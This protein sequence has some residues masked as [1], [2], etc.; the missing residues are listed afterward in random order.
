MDL[1]VSRGVRYRVGWRGKIVVSWAILLH[2]SDYNKKWCV[3][4]MSFF[5]Y[6]VVWS[7]VVRIQRLIKWRASRTGKGASVVKVHIGRVFS[8]SY[9]AL[10]H[11][12][13]MKF[14]KGPPCRVCCWM[15]AIHNQWS[16]VLRIWWIRE[17]TTSNS[18]YQPAP[19]GPPPIS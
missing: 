15:K 6:V 14:L 5:S 1:T 19:A 13:N 8:K 3:F 12:Y 9:T 10:W 17:L 4:D 18:T 7:V 11:P 16:S 2:C